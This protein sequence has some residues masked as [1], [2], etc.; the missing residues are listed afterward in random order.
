MNGTPKSWDPSLTSKASN[1]EAS[2]L[3]TCILFTT[4]SSLILPKCLGYVLLSDD[5]NF[6]NNLLSLTIYYCANSCFLFT[7]PQTDC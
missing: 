5:I 2:P 4:M 3:E 7:P 1:K 6:P